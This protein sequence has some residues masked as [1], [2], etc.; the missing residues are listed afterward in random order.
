MS[1]FQII[2]SIGLKSN[3]AIER[4]TNHSKRKCAHTPVE[5][6]GFSKAQCNRL[7]VLQEE[8]KQFSTT[9]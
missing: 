1:T 4:C 2:G 3:R 6:L 5:Q 7:K 8:M 9:C